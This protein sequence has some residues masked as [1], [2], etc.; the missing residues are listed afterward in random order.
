ML[1]AQRNHHSKFYLKYDYFEYFIPIGKWVSMFS[2]LNCKRAPNAF[3]V[4]CSIVLLGSKLTTNV[5]K[6]FVQFVLITLFPV[7]FILFYLI[8]MC[9]RLN[10]WKAFGL[11]C[12]IF[13]ADL[14]PCS[15]AFPG[16]SWCSRP[17]RSGSASGCRSSSPAPASCAAC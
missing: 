17:W 3:V 1:S 14:R 6:K 8:K 11:P 12:W 5:S 13:F 4:S 10:D 9:F 16:A 7:I 2:F 15:G